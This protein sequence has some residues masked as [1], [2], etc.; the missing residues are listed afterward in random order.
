MFS[1]VVGQHNEVSGRG[2]LVAGE[3]N[4]NKVNQSLTAGVSLVTDVRTWNAVGRYN[5]L[6]DGY[7]KVF[8]VGN[9]K[10]AENR[11]NAF[12]VFP[13]G[14]AE[15]AKTGDSYKSVPQKDYV[16]Y[17]DNSIIGRLEKEEIRAKAAEENL[18][19]DLNTETSNREKD[20]NKAREE[21]KDADDAI[22]N[23]LSSKIDSEIDRSTDAESELSRRLD[24]VEGEGEGS[25]KKAV[26]DEATI[27]RAAEEA[28]ADAVSK[29]K[30]RAEGVEVTLTIIT[31]NNAKAISDEKTRAT[32][33][34]TSLQSQIDAITASS[35]VKDIVGTKAQLN[36]YPTKD[37][38][39][40]DIIK[41]LKDESADDV[42]SYYR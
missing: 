37:L 23:D 25:I 32:A 9:G 19:D 16:D 3:G 17:R 29:E 31:Q 20:V 28:N 36:A 26:A 1:G 35:D 6:D 27:A 11:S 14:H 34:E 13:D 15:V 39:D 40:N 42:I 12:E 4:T 21:F 24:V 33:E 5:A 7:V 38:G 22:R 41:V 8:V 18:S 2:S 10:D 30:S